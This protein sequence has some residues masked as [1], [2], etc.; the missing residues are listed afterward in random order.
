MMAEQNPED[1]ANRIAI[2]ERTVQRLAKEVTKLTERIEELENQ[3]Q[4]SRVKVP[5]A[6][7]RFPDPARPPRREPPGRKFPRPPTGPEID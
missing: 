1:E 6:P 5:V 3:L 7:P 2:L 4:R